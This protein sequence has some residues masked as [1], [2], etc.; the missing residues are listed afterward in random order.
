M[1]ALHDRD[2]AAG[3]GPGA[4]NPA[5]MAASSAARNAARRSTPRDRTLRPAGGVRWDRIT[6]WALLALVAVLLLL[7]VQ[8]LRSYFSSSARAGEQARQV[9]ELRAEHTRLLRQRTDLGKPGAITEQARKMGMIKP[10]EHPFV[11]SGLS[12]DRD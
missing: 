3:D 9:Q 2:R 5:A 1:R 6:R 8:P 7:Y 10:G 12:G 4:A 11:V